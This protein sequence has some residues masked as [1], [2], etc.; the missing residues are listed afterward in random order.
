MTVVMMVAVND[1]D[2]LSLRR[3]RYGEAEDENQSEEDLFHT[4]SISLSKCDY[5]A[6]VISGCRQTID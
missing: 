5:R 3:I 2:Y 6:I 4:L 1:Y